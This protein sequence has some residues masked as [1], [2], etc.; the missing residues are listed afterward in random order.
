MTDRQADHPVMPQFLDRWSPR[1]FADKP[2]EDSVLM[3]LFE[4]ARW[5]PSAYNYQPWRFAYARRGD[6]HWD[7]FMSALVPFNQSWVA[8]AAVL[9]YVISDGIMEMQGDR[10]PN[11]SHSFDAGAA[12]M[13]LALQAHDMGLATHGMT[14]V[15]FDAAAKVLNVKDDFRV[16]AAVAI[17]WP[18]DPQSLPDMLREREVKSV[19]RPIAES[20]FHG[21]MVG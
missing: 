5:S 19:R 8:N 1:A 4:A 21:P 16:E 12:W 3:S 20:L 14:G 18:G 13:A 10:K 9:V 17:G 7:A 11:H 15:D 6:A 2:I